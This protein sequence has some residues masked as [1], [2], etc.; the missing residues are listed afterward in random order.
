MENQ[1]PHKHHSCHKA[2]KS[3]RLL[4][5]HNLVTD[6]NPKLKTSTRSVTL[7]VRL[8][9]CMAEDRGGAGTWTTW[10]SRTGSYTKPKIPP[11]V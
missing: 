11:L 7:A 8:S 9:G 6:R 10:K 4:S 3:S 1:W 2:R 5:R